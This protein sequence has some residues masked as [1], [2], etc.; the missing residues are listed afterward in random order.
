MQKQVQYLKKD[1]RVMESGR[2]ITLEDPE[3]SENSN[4]VVLVGT[5]E[6]GGAPFRYETV[7]GDRWEVV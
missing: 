2:L 4:R 5:Y 1:D 6:D 7:Q 3:I